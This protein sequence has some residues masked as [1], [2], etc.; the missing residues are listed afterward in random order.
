[1]PDATELNTTATSDATLLA[2]TMFGDGIQ[3]VSATL[4]GAATQAGTYEGGE[5]TSDGVVPSDSGVILSTGDIADFTS[6]G[7]GTDTNTTADTGTGHGGAGDSD[8]DA[9]STV[10]TNDAV[11]F[12]S[13]FIPDD[14]YI[15]MQLVFSSEEYLEYVNGGFSDTLGI[16]VNDEFVPLTSSGDTVSIDTVNDNSNSNL[17]IDNP[18]NAD[19]YNTEMDGF[20]TTLS[21]K[22]PVNAGED[23][24]IKIGLAD[25][26]DDVY[27]SNVLIAAD[28]VQ[29]VALAFEDEVTLEA[30]TT[31]IIDV[32]ANDHDASGNGLTITE[33]NGEPVQPGDSVTLNTGETVTLNADYTFSVET[34]SDLGETVFTYTVENS[35]G[36]SDVG[37]VII[38]TVAD[39]P[40]DGIVEGSGGADVIDTSFT[41]DPEGDMID[42]GDAIGVNGT[43]G[44]D[45]YVLAHGGGDTVKSGAGDDIV[46]GGTGDDALHGEAGND[47]LYGEDGTDEMGGGDGDDVLHGGADGDG[48]YGDAGNDLLDGGTGA[49]L[50]TGG[51]GD[52]TI[53][54]TDGFGNDTIT[55]GET[56]ETDGDTLDMSGVGAGVQLDL[57]GNDPEAGSVF[58]NG[59]PGSGSARFSEIENIV[60]SDG[61]DT[62]HL[63]DNSGQDAVAGF[64]INDSG[65]G[66]ALDQLDVS[67]LTSDGGYTPVTTTDVDVTSDP[68]GNAVLTFPGGEAITLE[69]VNPLDLSTVDD[70][71]AIGIPDGRDYIVEGT[72]GGEV[73]DTGYTGDPE[74]DMVDAGD[75]LD[76]S[77]DDVIEA[78]AGDDTVLAGAGADSVRAGEGNDSVE[79]GAGEDSLYGDEGDDTLLGGAGDDTIDGYLGADSIEGGDGNDS[80]SGHD[81]DD[82]IYGGAGDDWLRGSVGNDE[83]WGGTGD[84]YIWSG[85]N[86]DTIRIENDFGN[87]TIEAEGLNETT[88]DVLDLSLVT[89]GLTIDLTDSNPEDGS[90]SDGTSTATFN[91]IENIV[92][93]GGNDTLVL[94]DLSGDDFVQGFDLADDDGDGFTNDQLDVSQL[95][96][97]WGT[98][99]V[100]A[101]DVTV[102]DSNGDGTGDA[103]LSFPG[104]E[105]ITLVGVTPDQVDTIPELFSIGIPCF[106]PGARIVTMHGEK[107]VEDI[108]PGDM[109]LTADNG[110]QPVRWV[111]SRSLCAAE[112]AARPELKPYVIRKHAFGNARKMVVSPQHGFVMQTDTGERLIRAK[113]AAE[114]FGGQIARR[115]KA[116]EAVTY[117]H[118]LF[119]RHEIVFAEGARTEAFYPGPQ[120]L[121]SIDREAAMELLTLFPELAKVVFGDAPCAKGY[122]PPAR[123]YLKGREIRAMMSEL[124]NGV[125]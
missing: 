113:H 99:P 29:T 105:S 100:T 67:K 95:T 5:A 4:T 10:S 44:D 26:G 114:L 109:V 31:A 25:G 57:T 124:C 80:I 33:L 125:R 45:D 120:A 24:T 102:T 111:G 51:S 94:D 53:A 87:D 1:M 73:I 12:E 41:G 72:S 90:F 17:Y 92:L 115:D 101:W 58:E 55:G 47:S 64:D 69:G 83:M 108:R 88:G 21:F 34:D 82:T 107:P 91:E 13:T 75:A 65:D 36:T 76:G 85:Y 48:V 71:V 14:D 59:T 32:L 98:T 50:V 70:L 9:I 42:A 40:L 43:T 103:I 104:P 11:V 39:A 77:D 16:W 117:I 49:D 68:Y 118:I 3:V 123:A 52:D 19:T 121:K 28:S 15:T 97:D 56:G 18:Q 66:T 86:D 81:G 119:D 20:T 8:L 35:E 46:Y 30:N 74:G 23:N 110:F 7:G 22:A 38:Q 79:G 63:A 112:L 78:G 37:Y 6:G 54:L 106:T 93:G 2:N 84:D 62:V 96:S 61:R 122:G 116:C 89:D 60:L 27:D